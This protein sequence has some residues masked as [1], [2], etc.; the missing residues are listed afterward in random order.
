MRPIG[1]ATLTRPASISRFAW[2]ASIGV[3]TEPGQ[4]QVTRI[5]RGPYSSAATRVMAMTAAF[6]AGSDGRLP[7][8]CPTRRR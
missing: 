2:A 4:M 3:S 5:P 8:P 6:E 7:G 1:D